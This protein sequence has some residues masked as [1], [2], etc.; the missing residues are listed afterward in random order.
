MRWIGSSVP[1]VSVFLSFSLSLSLSLPLCLTSSLCALTSSYSRD[2]LFFP[3]WRDWYINQWVSLRNHVL[4]SSCPTVLRFWFSFSLSQVDVS[5]ATLCFRRRGG[6]EIKRKRKVS[7]VP[8][9]LLSWEGFLLQEYFSIY[10]WP[11]FCHMIFLL[12]YY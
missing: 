1:P 4:P 6:S 9:S 7:C 3:H 11:G 2:D 12:Y 10:H 5:S 8:I